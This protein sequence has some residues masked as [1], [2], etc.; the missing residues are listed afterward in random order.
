MAAR[1]GRT[2]EIE[3]QLALR[4][5]RT[6]RRL[7]AARSGEWTVEPHE[8]VRLRDSYFDTA[9]WR[10]LRAGYALRVRRSGTK[11]EATLK[12]LARARRGPAKRREITAPLANARPAT[13]LRARGAVATWMRRAIGDARL[14]RLFAVRT[15]REV[16]AVRHRGRI[17]AE[18][19]LDSTRI[20]AR[21]RERCLTRVEVEVTRGPTALVAR[22]VATL[23]RGRHLTLARRSKFEEGLRTA[24]LTPPRVR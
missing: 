6:V 16:F 7:T 12:A 10:V 11:V 15:R 23:R 8:V 24:G 20:L 3:W 22:F 18:L 19:A 21:G 2:I 5:P 13:L 1:V 14:R 4:D 17:V 9:D